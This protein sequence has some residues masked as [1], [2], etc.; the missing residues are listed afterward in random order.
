MLLLRP[1]LKLEVFKVFKN[2][3]IYLNKAIRKRIVYIVNIIVHRV[4]GCGKKINK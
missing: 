3:E 1:S 4:C 2:G